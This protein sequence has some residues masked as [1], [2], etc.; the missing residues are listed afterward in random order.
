MS[1]CLM[2]LCDTLLITI[3]CS[4][5]CMECHAATVVP[6]H[7]IHGKVMVTV[8]RPC[9]IV[10]WCDFTQLTSNRIQLHNS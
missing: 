8:I 9:D 3:T 7:I 5:Y 2:K 4:L 6:G 1:S 10:R